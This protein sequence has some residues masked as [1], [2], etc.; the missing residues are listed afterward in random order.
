MMVTKSRLHA[1]R[2]KQAFDRYSKEQGLPYKALVAFSGTVKDGTLEF[3]ETGM[4]GFSEKHTAEEFKKPNYRFL[5]AANKFQTGFDQPLL[6]VMYVDK[7]LGGGKPSIAYTIKIPQFTA[8]A[9]EKVKS[10]GGEVLTENG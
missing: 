10:V 2:F 3:T 6:S 9:E 1:V 8:V 5:I 4:N 7:L